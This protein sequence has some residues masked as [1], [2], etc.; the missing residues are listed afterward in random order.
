MRSRNVAPQDAGSGSA[1][2][3]QK[4]IKIVSLIFRRKFIYWR[5]AKT[6]LNG[7]Y[8]K[9]IF[10]GLWCYY[11][12]LLIP[13]PPSANWLRRS[14]L[15]LLFVLPSSSGV[16]PIRATIL[17]SQ[18]WGARFAMHVALAKSSDKWSWK[19]S[20][21]DQRFLSP[22][23]ASPRHSIPHDSDLPWHS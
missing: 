13:R 1:F 22:D 7:I 12:T 17:P 14:S 4:R 5:R 20:K 10:N 11:S 3:R 15:C 19:G 8:A 16:K 9:A 23:G 6:I 2:Q 18:G 21:S